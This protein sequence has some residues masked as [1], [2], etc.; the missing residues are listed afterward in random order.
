MRDGGGLQLREGCSEKLSAL[1]YHSGRTYCKIIPRDNSFCNNLCNYYKNNCTTAFSLQCYCRW[2]VLVCERT[3]EAICFVKRLFCNFYKINCAKT[4]TAIVKRYGDCWEMLV[5]PRRPKGTRCTQ[6]ATRLWIYYTYSELTV[7]LWFAIVTS[8]A[9]KL[10]FWV[11]QAFF[12]SKPR[13]WHSQ[14]GA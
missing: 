2:F 10:F 3:C 1:V 6:N 8:P 5:F 14:F 7:E 9:T 12:L 4:T 11:L 13:A